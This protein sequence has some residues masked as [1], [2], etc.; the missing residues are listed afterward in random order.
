M[1]D[2]THFADD[3]VMIKESRE[4]VKETNF[5]KVVAYIGTRQICIIIL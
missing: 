5:G 2:C 1:S 3:I 4:A